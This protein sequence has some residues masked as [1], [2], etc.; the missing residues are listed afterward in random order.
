[1]TGKCVATLCAAAAAMFSMTG[2]ASAQGLFGGYTQSYPVYTQPCATGNCG[3]R[4]N[5]TYY[6]PGSP[7]ANGRCPTG[8]VVPTSAYTTSYPSANC[9][10]G[11]C[12]PGQCNCPTGQCRTICG[13][14]GCQQICTP[15]NGYSNMNFAPSA[16]SALPSLNLDQQPAWNGNGGF[17]PPM[18]MN[19][20][21]SNNG[22]NNNSFNSSGFSGAQNFGT[23]APPR[24]FN[25]PNFS[26]MNGPMNSGFVPAG[27]ETNIANDPLV[28]LN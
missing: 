7:C 15:S 13:P 26:G 10:N 24:S 12:P 21:Y 25:R 16:T 23:V 22:F 17:V 27:M 11:V 9:P 1:M 4:T 28:R 14:N 2:S 3:V 5:T 8:T 19:N 18:N 20:G 6:A